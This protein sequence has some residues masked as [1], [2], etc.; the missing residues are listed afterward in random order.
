METYR[1]AGAAAMVA[2]HER[3]MRAFLAEW[4]D[5]RGRGAAL[6]ATQDPDYVSYELLLRHVLGAARG[7]L[8]WMCR[9][10][11]LPD[12]GLAEPP[13]AAALA[14]RAE[15]YLET[16]LERWKTP[17]AGVEEER[18][19]RPAHPTSAGVDLSVESMLEHAVLHPMRH[20]YQLERLP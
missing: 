1:Y 2:L 6:P 13:E 14:A 4:E 20:R 11:E 12:P 9:S 16:L 19:F 18:F 15:A 10:L 7:Y 5:A 8:R 17:L 3:E